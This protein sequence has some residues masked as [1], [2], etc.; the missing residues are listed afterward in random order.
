MDQGVVL[1]E[2][3]KPFMHVSQH[4][5]S[6]RR[7]LQQPVHEDHAEVCMLCLKSLEVL[8]CR[9]IGSAGHQDDSERSIR[10]RIQRGNM[11]NRSR[12][13]TP[14]TTISEAIAPLSMHSN[15]PTVC[16]GL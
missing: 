2:H 6:G 12:G 8:S 9:V 11:L 15:G 5:V 7:L 1:D 13:T 10:M 4:D 16:E 3:A 14:I